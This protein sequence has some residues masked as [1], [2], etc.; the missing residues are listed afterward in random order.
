MGPHTVL[1]GRRFGKL[2]AI[3]RVESPSALSRSKPYYKCLCD[4]GKKKIVCAS[5]LTN[6]NTRSC[7]CLQREKASLNLVNIVGER[8]GK[9]LVLSRSEVPKGIKDNREA[10]FLCR[11]DCGKEKIIR[12]NSLRSGLTTSCGC[13]HKE[14]LSTARKPLGVS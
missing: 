13:F 7:G 6:G 5:S 2:L 3:E 4:C 12:G 10:F 14:K 9:I 11:C 8:F 1:N